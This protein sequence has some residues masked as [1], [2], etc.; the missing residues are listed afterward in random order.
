MN[1]TRKRLTLIAGLYVSQ[2]IP[3]GFLIVAMPAILRRRGMGLELTGLLGA[4]ALPWLIKFLWAPLID[5]FGSRRWGHYRSW[6]IPLQS[7]TVLV[8]AAVSQLDLQDGMLW[9]IVAGAV[10]MLSS[11]TQDIAT[12]GLAVHTVRPDERGKANGIQV[13]GYY[14][15]QILGG[16]LVLVL[17]DRVGWTVALL[18]MA[19]LLAMPLIPLL[20]FKEPATHVARKQ[21]KVDFDALR[22]FTKRP[23]AGIWILILL[24]YRAGETMAMTMFNPML[25]DGGLSLEAIGV[26]VGVIGSLGAFA[27][28]IAGGWLITTIGRKTSLVL[29]G[30]MQ[31]LALCAYLVPAGGTF[32]PGAIY[33]VVL[34]VAFASGMATA[35][36]YTN[37]MDRCDPKTAATDFTLQQS[38]CAFGPLL[39]SSLSGFSAA[40]FG[41]SMHFAICAS[42]ALAS[43]LVAARWLTAESAVPVIAEPVAESN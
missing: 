16:G 26:T 37:M 20:R 3:L 8:V 27:G 38:L 5:R 15:G 30:L 13:G 10:F 2:A 11:A 17:F 43:T 22:R 29:F 36:L 41:Y 18:T 12:D 7:L 25:V 33:L 19:A 35:A 9:L 21:T 1:D 40:R 4:L 39:G 23:G 31:A 24:V 34:S 42:L 32:R 6:I 28:A 14:F